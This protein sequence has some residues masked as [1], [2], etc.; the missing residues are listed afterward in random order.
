MYLDSVII[1]KL[2]FRVISFFLTLNCKVSVV[3]I[4]RILLFNTQKVISPIIPRIVTIDITI[5]IETISYL[6]VSDRALVK[7][8]VTD[9][10]SS[11]KLPAKNSPVCPNKPNRG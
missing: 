2:S 9:S 3:A 8:L 4:S 6:L 11:K 5:C 1:L 7:Y 10:I